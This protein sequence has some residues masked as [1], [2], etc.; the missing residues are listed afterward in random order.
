[1]RGPEQNWKIGTI[2]WRSIWY[3]YLLI[4]EQIQMDSCMIAPFAG[5]WLLSCLAAHVKDVARLEPGHWS[6][7]ARSPAVPDR[8]LPEKEKYRYLF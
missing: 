6:E 3:L 4:S 1:M 8:A 5:L 7:A 2:T